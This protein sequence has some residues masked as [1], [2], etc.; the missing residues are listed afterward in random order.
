LDEWPRVW[1]AHDSNDPRMED[2]RED[3]V[4]IMH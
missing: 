3:R 2:S 1:G 4:A